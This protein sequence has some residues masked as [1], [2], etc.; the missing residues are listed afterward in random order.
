MGKRLLLDPPTRNL[1]DYLEA[2][3][4]LSFIGWRVS[5]EELFELGI[6]AVQ[7]ARHDKEE[8]VRCA[9][10]FLREGLLYDVS[11]RSA[12]GDQERDLMVMTMQ[13][14][15]LMVYRDFHRVLFSEGL[16]RAKVRVERYDEIYLALRVQ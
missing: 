14:V 10:T 15:F 2:Q 9:E 5:L 4:D 1:P 7:R 16:S 6:M 12:R 8:L 13:A 11:D 3:K